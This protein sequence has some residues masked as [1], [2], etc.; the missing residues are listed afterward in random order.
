[1]KRFVYI[2]LFITTI[3]TQAQSLPELR[4]VTTVP[5][6]ADMVRQI[7]G[8]YVEVT[9]LVAI[10]GDPLQHEVTM[11]DLDAVDNADLL[12]V[13]GTG[14]E[15]FLTDL[16]PNT[17]TPYFVVSEGVNMLGRPASTLTPA[18]VSI[19]MTLENISGNNLSLVTAEGDWF[20]G[21]MMHETMLMN[22]MAM[23]SEMEEI[24][25]P[26]DE[27]V[28]FA[29]AS[30]HLMLLGVRENLI[31]DT[32]KSFTLRF[33]D[34]SELDVPISV[35]MDEIASGAAINQTETNQLVVR[36]VWA[37]PINVAI[38]PNG[39]DVKSLGALGDD[40]ICQNTAISKEPIATCL[41]YVYLDPANGNQWASTIAL[42]LADLDPENAADY[43][44][45]LMV[46]HEQIA[47]L[48]EALVQVTSQCADANIGVTYPDDWAYFA[49][50]YEVLFVSD[51]ESE[52][53]TILWEA[54]GYVELLGMLEE[55]LST[56]GGCG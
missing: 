35:S 48:N 9:S 37:Y 5:I 15:P 41:P 46:Y 16:L 54:E 27:T 38:Y 23:M 49:A 3:V 19:Y 36:D 4:V 52:W 29:P 56:G 33:S 28:V 2:I 1:M 18:D 17:D 12:F 45:N 21:A 7:G 53:D 42:I 40:V 11:D 13:A 25:L 44:A 10:G 32:D 31:A 43:A 39:N 22:E 8:E 14:L 51:A 20:E 24:P 26:P 30:L 47:L 50:R 6:L 34:G 55:R